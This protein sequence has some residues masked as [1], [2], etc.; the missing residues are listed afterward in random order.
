MNIKRTGRVI[1]M[2]EIQRQFDQ[3]VNRVISRETKLTSPDMPLLMAV[4]DSLAELERF[5][6][7]RLWAN[8][9]NR[10]VFFINANH[11]VSVFS[12][13]PCKPFMLKQGE[14]FSHISPLSGQ[15]AIGS[16]GVNDVLSL[17]SII[18][19]ETQS[20]MNK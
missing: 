2:N 9:Q 19:H 16:D 11:G 8:E 10:V 5:R 12:D 7:M 15:H 1:E 17:A 13:R 4:R 14:S 18:T 3:F 6:K 20:F